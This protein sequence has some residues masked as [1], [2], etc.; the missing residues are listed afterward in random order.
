MEGKSKQQIVLEFPDGRTQAYEAG[1][2]ALNVARGI[3]EGL[4]RATVAAVINDAVVDLTHPIEEDSTIRLLTFRDRQGVEVFHHS[5]AHLLAQAVT[6]LF[7]EARPTIGPPVDEG[8]Y[9][10]FDHEP[11][12]AEDVERIEQKMKELAKADQQIQRVELTREEALERFKD[13]PYKTEMIEDLEDGTISAYQQGDFMDLC[14]GPHVPTTRMFKG[15]KVL[16]VAGAYW[17]GDARNQQLQRIYAITFPDK[18]QLKQH[19]HMLEEAKKRDHRK[20]GRELDLFSFHAE[21]PGF[22]F[23]HNNG[24]L[25]KEECVKYWREVHRKHNYIEI[26]T[27]VML[28]ETLWHRSG[29]AS[30]YRENMYFS[31]VDERPFAIKPMN[32]PGGLLYFVSKRHSYRDLPAR[33]AE[34]G[35]VHRHE[36]SG[37]LHGLFRV[38]CFTQDDA[39][40]YCTPEQLT[41]EVVEVVRLVFEIYKTFG[42]S[43]VKVELSTRPE[44]RIGSDDVWDRA[45]AALQ[46]ALEREEIDY[47]LNPGDGAFYGPKIDFHIRDCMNRSWQCGTVQVDFSLPS[48]ERFNATY[49]GAD[50]QRHEA[51]MVHRAILGSLE[52]FIGILLEHYAG[53]LPLWL[54]PRQARIIPV[55]DNFLDYARSVKNSLAD[56]GLKVDVDDRNETVSK[57]VRHAQLERCNFQLVVGG[58]EEEDGTVS[59]RTRTN[60]QLGTMSVDDFASM[61]QRKIEDRDNSEE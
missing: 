44:K 48:K 15:I 51:V 58:R 6:Q 42:F 59:V 9:Y 12:T 50:G 20:V 17:R 38:R 39:H 11:F 25:L 46:A 40:V 21:G 45:E 14:R 30:Y 54:S 34:L 56:A 5:G 3:S 35:L 26:S 49:E 13:N 4:A 24:M 1:T 28:D 33:V 16:K 31:D 19:L 36:M 53:K 2:S 7:P 37:V 52:R 10:D 57:K 27:P 61:A 43:D 32:C 41:D 29:H 8:F 60:K 18:K 55:S 23:W 47:E 22:P